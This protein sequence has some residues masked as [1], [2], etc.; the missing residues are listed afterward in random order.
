MERICHVRSTFPRML[1]LSVCVAIPL[2]V[3]HPVVAAS[4]RASVI[5]DSAATPPPP[6]PAP[7]PP[8]APEPAPAPAPAPAPPPAPA[9]APTP[10]VAPAPASADT[11]H[12]QAPVD[13]SAAHP[14]A[15]AIAPAAAGAAAAGAAAA[16]AAPL[17]KKQQREQEKAAKRAAKQAKHPKK[18]LDVD[19]LEGWNKGKSWVSVRA[20]YAKS[21]QT[22][23][24]NGNA[25]AGAG[26]TRFLSAR[27]SLGLIVQGD[28]LGKFGGAADIEYPVTLEIARHIRWRTALRPYFGLGGGAYY[29]KYFRTGDDEAHWR[30]GF[31]L[32]GG[33]NAPIGGRNILGVDGRIQF[34]SG[35]PAV[36]NPVFGSEA[37]QNVHY[38]LKMAYSRI[39]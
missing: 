22:G 2:V 35:D 1:A 14:G 20:G 30:S 6:A 24:A 38:S 27:W 21:T 8:P 4:L 3:A 16:P 19:P 33:A 15:P 7:A 39:F 34:V 31:Y 12:A 36:T 25:G 37:S 28:V 32:L 9:P 23:A 26:Y 29:H 10:P 17:T 5:A 13:T 18:P 11:A